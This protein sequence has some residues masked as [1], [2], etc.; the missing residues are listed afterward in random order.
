[1]KNLKIKLVNFLYS[2]AFLLSWWYG[3]WV[4]A[5][6]PSQSKGELPKYK[7]IDEIIEALDFGRDYEMDPL[8]G[9][10]DIMYH[11][12]EVQDR[13]NNGEKVG[14]CDDH[15]IYWASCLLK[16]NFA[17]NVWIG[18]A[19]YEGKDGKLAGHAIC[20]FEDY[21]DNLYWADYR[22]PYAVDSHEEWAEHVGEQKYGTKL[23]ASALVPVVALGQHDMPKFGKSFRVT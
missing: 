6:A 5:T 4:K 13:I 18:T 20:V 15:A 12:R 3:F 10:L 7:S 2:F 14:D 22:M 21:N 17:R 23:I 11:P 8:K 9:L 19:F 1:M 16:S